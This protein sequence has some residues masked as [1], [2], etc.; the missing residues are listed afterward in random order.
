MD[1]SG[2][3]ARH[4]LLRASMAAATALALFAG[5]GA[6]CVRPWVARTPPPPA[7]LQ[8]GATID[9]VIT[10]VHANT[11]R[12]TSL[13]SDDAT[14]QV[15]GVSP[16][17]TPPLTGRIALQPTRS[18]RLTAGTRL[19]GKEVDLGSNDQMFWLW[20]KRG[21][22]PAVYFADHER[23]RSSAAAA[24]LGIE[25]SW[26][27]QAIGLTS[28]GIHETHDGPT[29]REDGLLQ[30]RST[31]ETPLG[32]RSR[33]TILDGRTAAVMEQHVYDAS[34]G[35]L[36][37]AIVKAHRYYPQHQ[38]TLPQVVEIDW[39]ASQ[40]TLT[41]NLGNV[42]INQTSAATGS[43]FQMPA[44]PNEQK[45]DLA[46]SVAPSA[47]QLPPITT[48]PPPPYPTSRLPEG[49]SSPVELP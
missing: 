5:S 44:F 4:R 35:R 34:G 18:I 29:P 43:L 9:E 30:I 42:R 31:W 49:A 37:S 27:I 1:S 26:L 47:G 14:I 41:V 21:Q 7:V 48:Q 3:Q 10:A 19:L 40:L 2:I 45:I 38:V 32:P 25:P 8:P 23:F 22:P 33:L 39:P 20:V 24:Q 13:Q 6:T 46:A 12:I 11:A 36:G 15:G 16:V 28:F 17:G